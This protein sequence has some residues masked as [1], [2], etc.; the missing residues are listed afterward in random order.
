LAEAR[1]PAR[2]FR[3]DVVSVVVEKGLVRVEHL[4]DAFRLGD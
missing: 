1:W 3:F 4:A 2:A